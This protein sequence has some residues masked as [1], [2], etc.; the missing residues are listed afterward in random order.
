VKVLLTGHHGYIGSVTR[1]ALESAGH[2]VVGL[3]TFYYRGCDFG[4]EGASGSALTADLRDITAGQLEGFDAVVHL[5]ALS[6]D[7]LGD[8][9][10]EW[11]YSINFDGTVSLARA[12]RTAGV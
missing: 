10:T 1:S 5:A 11:T 9:R 12:A 2:Y 8:L 3:D 7:P 4:P 6:N